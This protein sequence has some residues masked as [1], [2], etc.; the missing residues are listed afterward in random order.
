MAGR[1]R[2]GKYLHVRAVAV[3]ARR[4]QLPLQVEVLPP[5]LGHGLL[6][7]RYFLAHL[8][9]VA[10]ALAHRLVGRS[11]L[12]YVLAGFGQDSAFAL[13]RGENRSLVNSRASF[14]CINDQFS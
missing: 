8:L 11:E 3:L 13:S 9:V 1:G 2:L 4:R 6:Q 5:E 10:D 14:R 7:R 12:G